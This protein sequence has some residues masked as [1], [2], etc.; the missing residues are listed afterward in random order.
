MFAF[1]MHKGILL[2]NLVQYSAKS[3][4]LYTYNADVVNLDIFRFIYVC[5]NG[6]VF[7]YTVKY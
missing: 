4:Y 1:L 6:H 7:V 3:W 2:D 5:V